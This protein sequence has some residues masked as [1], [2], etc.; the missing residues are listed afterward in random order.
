MTYK[1]LF[2]L[3]ITHDYYTDGRCPDFSF[4]SSAETQV[5]LKNYR[6]ILKKQADGLSILIPILET[7]QVFIPLSADA[8]F[9]FSIL[10]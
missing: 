9:S 2:K 8:V 5:L 10:Q 7:G 4:E 6:C 3:F 1:T